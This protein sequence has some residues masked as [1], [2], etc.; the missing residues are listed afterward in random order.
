[1]QRA[2]C[3]VIPTIRAFQRF[4]GDLVM[5]TETRNR[6]S[7]ASIG[8]AICMCATAPAW[9]DQANT[10]TSSETSG[11]LEEI[12]VTARKSSESIQTTPVAVTALSHEMLIQQQVIDVADLQHAAPDVT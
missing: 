3:V 6:L 10:A 7:L 8:L 1:M 11:G 5:D 12:L 4:Q 2:T 9:G